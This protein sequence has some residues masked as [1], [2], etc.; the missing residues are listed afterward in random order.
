MEKKLIKAVRKRP[1]LYDTAHCDYTRGKVKCEKWEEVGKEADFN[2]GAEAKSV[3]EKLRHAFRDALRR[4][5]K[6]IRNG[7]SDESIKLWKYQREMGF[8]QC[9]MT[10]GS[11]NQDRNLQDDSDTD[12]TQVSNIDHD[13][14][15]V[16]E[17][18]HTQNI[19]SDNDYEL[20]DDTHSTNLSI[21]DITAHISPATLAPSSLQK[22]TNVILRP[23]SKIKENNITALMKQN[24]EILRQIS[25]QRSEERKRILEEIE[26]SKDPLYHFFIFVYETTKKMPPSYQYIV[27]NE[28]YHAVSNM[29]AKLLKLPQ[30]PC[31]ETHGYCESYSSSPYHH[32]SSNNSTIDASEDNPD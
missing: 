29:E 25:D 16:I 31:N 5:Q 26:I 2:S 32:S 19:M 7:A 18:P 21:K 27:R 22:N 14:C 11:K 9:F 28:V 6:M 23:H 15:T 20:R 10:R 12:G 1:M 3:W 17:E 24:M 30:I 13:D 4:Q 8:L